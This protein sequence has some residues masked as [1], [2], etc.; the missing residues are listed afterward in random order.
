MLCFKKMQQHCRK[1]CKTVAL[2][3][4]QN[5]RK[6]RSKWVWMGELAAGGPGGSKS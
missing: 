5:A 3:N 1:N 2:G 6:E 4:M